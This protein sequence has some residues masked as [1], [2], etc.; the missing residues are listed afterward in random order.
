[1]KNKEIKHQNLS[2]HIVRK[3]SGCMECMEKAFQTHDERQR[4]S[5]PRPFLD[6]ILMVSENPPGCPAQDFK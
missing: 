6:N 5:M 4:I 2:E 1:M 3:R